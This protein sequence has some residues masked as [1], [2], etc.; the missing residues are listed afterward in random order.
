MLP[1]DDDEF[2]GD[3]ASLIPLRG[4]KLPGP[5]IALARQRL[6][7]MVLAGT[8]EQ[9]TAFNI[10]YSGRSWR[11][12][13]RQ[14]ASGGYKLLFDELSGC[15]DRE[16]FLLNFDG[17]VVTTTTFDALFVDGAAQEEIDVP[18]ITTGTK[19]TKGYEIPTALAG[20]QFITSRMPG[21]VYTGQMRQFVQCYYLR[22]VDVPLV[23]DGHRAFTNDWG[24]CQVEY[25]LVE[26]P[27]P[28]VVGGTAAEERENAR[29]RR[30][31]LVEV[32]DHG[33]YALRVS[34]NNQQDPTRCCGL[35]L[36]VELKTKEMWELYDPGV[37]PYVQLLTAA[38]MSAVYASGAQMHYRR[39]WAFSYSGHEAQIVLQRLAY[40]GGSTV[41]TVMSRWKITFTVT[42]GPLALGAVVALVEAAAYQG[43]SLNA[44]GG[45][46]DILL[47]DEGG[48]AHNV[49]VDYDSDATA[50]YT[51]NYIYRRTD[52]TA[53]PTPAVFQLRP[54]LVNDFNDGAVYDIP[55]HVY[56]WGDDAVVT[57]LGCTAIS[58]VPG[59]SNDG[60]A[61]P[62]FNVVPVG[63]PPVP[64]TGSR[65]ATVF[66][67]TIGGPF[68]DTVVL[69]M[70][71]IGLAWVNLVAFIVSPPVDPATT[72]AWV[73]TY[74]SA[75]GVCG[76][77]IPW[78]EREAV[79][80]S[81]QVASVDSYNIPPGFQSSFAGVPPLS[82]IT[83]LV[84]EAAYV[85]GERV[86]NVVGDINDPATQGFYLYYAMGGAQ[87]YLDPANP[88]D[89]DQRDTA[90]YITTNAPRPTGMVYSYM[91]TKA[92]IVGGYAALG[93]N[94]P[95]S[96][97][98]RT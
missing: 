29:A 39:G 96:F 88:Y 45:P 17:G 63:P 69:S 55:V 61:T 8:D 59:T 25:G 38:A 30:R 68:A 80:I 42:T 37:K 44:T 65:G 60:D 27:R 93:K 70:L 16:G 19:R 33:V 14:E 32:S 40:G 22:G 53:P 94:N 75:G 20:S 76:V 56:Y 52:I 36:P 10:S 13:A 89:V 23:E 57:R 54:A 58:V 41:Q 97:V 66:V 51:R 50:L 3:F 86:S 62:V 35:R 15:K 92:L 90:V 26:Y 31:W 12:T 79:G 24:F 6:S 7:D 85:R 83:G 49:P 73:W 18:P 46:P 43:S 48:N 2:E 74:R 21:S 72:E 64:D 34:S 67:S 5:L 91:E 1:N 11:V 98:G 4:T 77:I 87:F 84:R 95:R 82:A 47:P 9:H 71:S 78:L 28:R 81:G